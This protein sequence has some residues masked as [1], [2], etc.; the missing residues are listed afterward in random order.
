MLEMIKRRLK[1]ADFNLS[2]PSEI[3]SPIS[4]M[5]DE[6]TNMADALTQ[7]VYIDFLAESC[8][9][10]N[11]SIKQVLQNNFSAVLTFD[12]LQATSNDLVSFPKRQG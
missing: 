10:T 5:T 2:A 8:L 9:F 7:Q 4:I 12:S 6:K 11:L 3:T 1:F